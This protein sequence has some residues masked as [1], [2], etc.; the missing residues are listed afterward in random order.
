[1]EQLTLRPEYDDATK[2]LKEIRKKV[3][4]NEER[5]C[6]PYAT[7][8][9]QSKGRKKPEDDNLTDN[10]TDFARDRDRIIY[11]SA[12]FKLSGKTQVF[13]S[14]RNPLISNRMT[15]VIQVAQIAKSIARA[16]NANEDLTE[17]IALGHDLGHP[18][19]GHSGEKMLSEK[20]EQA[21]LGKFKHNVHSLRVIDV[22]EKNG[23]GLNLCWEVREGILC[24]DGEVRQGELTPCIDRVKKNVEDYEKE[25]Y[26]KPASTLEGCIVKICDKI[27]YAGKDIE[28]AIEAGLISRSDIPKECSDVLGDTNRKIIDTLVKDIIVNFERSRTEFVNKHGREPEK[29]EVKI[30]LSPKVRKAMDDLIFDF[31]YKRIYL[32]DE[33]LRYTRQTRAIVSGLFDAFLSELHELR[34]KSTE[35]KIFD[36]DPENKKSPEVQTRIFQTLLK[37]NLKELEEFKKKLEEDFSESMLV[38]IFPEKERNS[39]KE[40]LNAYKLGE[41]KNITKNEIEN[42]KLKILKDNIEKGPHPISSVLSFLKGKTDEYLLSVNCAEITRDYIASLTDELAISIFEKLHIPQSIV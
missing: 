33:N 28:D 37:F 14:P 41:I 6:A 32:S 36:F 10:R 8:S 30:M 19:F 3:V 17:A 25:D 1:M 18:P 9:S 40:S 29:H 35:K 34:I 13:M 5:N 31:N 26:Q 20:C 39:I 21:G 2:I 27:A 7:K 23:K 11:S 42:A 15:H 4:E 12:F 16:I 38:G 22:I 24:H